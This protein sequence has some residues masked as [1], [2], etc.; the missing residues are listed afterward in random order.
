VN[1]KIFKS[2]LFM[3]ERM[4]NTKGTTMTQIHKRFTAEQVKVLFQ[5]YCQGNLSRSDVEEMLG[6]GKTRFFAL[7]KIYRQDQDAF[8][9]AYHRSTQGRLSAETESQIEQELL[10]EKDLIA[11][12][13]LPIHDYNYSALVDR[14]K[15]KGIQVSTTTVIKRAKVLKCYKPKKKSKAHDQEVLT[16]SIGDLIQHDASLHKWSPYATEKW[17][18]ITSLDDYSRML[19]Y[20]DFVPEE[21]SWAHI[22]AAQYVLQTF[23]LP[24]RYY[25]DNL[26]V[27]RFV[28]KR[29]SFWRTHHLGT[30]DVDPQWKQVLREF[31]IDVIYA[32][33]PQAKGKVERPYRWL[34]DRIVR[35]CALEKLTDVEDVR[36]VLREEVHRYNYQQVHSTTGEVPAIRFANARKAGNSLFRPFTLP[37]PYKSV[38][39]VFCLRATRTVDGYRRISLDRHSIEVPKVGLREDVNLRLVPDFTKKILEVR[40]WFEGKMVRSVNLPLN[41]FRRFA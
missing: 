6:I 24:F 22:Q 29:D 40:I 30:D 20:A 35:T 19:L 12:K 16:A 10:R 25:V 15:K 11:D 4:T 34:Q 33:S 37:K 17:T 28:Q 13:D 31:N 36:E 5:G 23:G 7:L 14:L 41:E 2:E 8:S 1:I 21:S 18:L 3:V 38:K 9:I 27:F 26:R 39:D 32:L